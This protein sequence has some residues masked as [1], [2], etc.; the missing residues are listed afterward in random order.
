MIDSCSRSV[1]F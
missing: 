1:C